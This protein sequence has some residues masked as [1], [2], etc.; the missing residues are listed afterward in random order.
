MEPSQDTAA[1]QNQR[2]RTHP[3]FFVACGLVLMMGA[4]LVF[5]LEPGSG[6]GI[7]SHDVALTSASA[8]SARPIRTASV[9]Q[10]RERE[11]KARAEQERLAAEEAAEKARRAI[12]SADD[13]EEAK[14]RAQRDELARRQAAVEQARRAEVDVEEAWN[15]F[16]KPSAACKDPSAGATVECANEY[17]KAKREFSARQSGTTSR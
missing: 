2:P 6:P 4:G 13:A 7:G 15:R 10:I 5:W 14:A 11:A 16:F 9:E 12:V 17:V 3:V 8:P 1:T